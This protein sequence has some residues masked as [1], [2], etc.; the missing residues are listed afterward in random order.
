MRGDYTDPENDRRKAQRRSG[1]DQREMNH[2][3]L[4]G[5]DRRSTTRRRQERRV[6]TNSVLSGF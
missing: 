6:A 1:Q 3:E 4:D 5:D 2:S